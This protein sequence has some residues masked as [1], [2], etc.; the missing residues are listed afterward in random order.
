MT[1]SV[2][3]A[4]GLLGCS[5]AL[6][7]PAVASSEWGP[8][9]WLDD[10]GEKLKSTPEFY[11]DI[12]V[13]RLA[14]QYAAKD[15]P[16]VRKAQPGTAKAD[17]EDFEDALKSGRL[18]PADGTAV[19]TAHKDMRDWLEATDRSE[20][21]KTAEVDS[22]FAAYHQAAAQFRTGQLQD[23][24]AAWEKLLQR[25][26]GDRHYRS[27]WAAYMIGKCCLQQPDQRG[28][29]IEWFEKCR[30]LAC[31]GFVDSPGLAA[32]SFGWQARAEYDSGDFSAS[33][34]HYLQQL[35][36]GDTSAIASLKLMVPDRD[37]DGINLPLS[38]RTLPPQSQEDA[39]LDHRTKAELDEAH[40]RASGRLAAAV[41]DP[42]LRQLVTAHV[43]ATAAPLFAPV[44]ASRPNAWLDAVNKAGL[45]KIEGAASL[46]WVAYTAGRFPEAE[47]WLKLDQPA[48][49]LGQWLRA[50]LALR[51]GAFAEASG[52]L[53]TVLPELPEAANRGDDDEFGGFFPKET[54]A[55]DLGAA[56]LA[57]GKLIEA[58]TIF[59]NGGCP[60]DA[61]YLA[62][63]V[64][65]TAELM[66]FVKAQAFLD[67]KELP[68]LPTGTAVPDE[69]ERQESLMKLT[70]RRLIREGRTA[71]GRLLLDDEM[72]GIFD[73]FQVVTEL[74]NDPKQPAAS[75][76]RALFDAARLVE[77]H[78]Y[79][80]MGSW[81]DHGDDRGDFGPGY[82][83][84]DEIILDRL[85]GRTRGGGENDPGT[86][87]GRLYIPASDAERERLKKFS[88]ERIS[89]GKY[90]RL[91]SALAVKAAALLPDNAEETADVLNQA[92]RWIQDL[93]NHGADRIYY[94]LEKRCPHAVIGAAVIKK[95]WFIDPD[96]PWTR[97]PVFPVQ[98]QSGNS[99]E[100]AL[101]EK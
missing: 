37:L 96:G 46:G 52:I 48:T 80:W 86:K 11:W 81:N 1:S 47:K 85:A 95:H 5:L 3:I 45:T 8:I 90:R 34:R 30:Q 70:G 2:R 89:I 66:S 98:E 87:P 77:A 58:F 6:I 27:V 19:K 57:Q 61:A 23:A 69:R 18:K 31:D 60:K 44:N 63:H 10:G 67:W 76:G 56:L 9:R 29:A 54:A 20:P 94:Q 32:D 97:E 64:L 79:S 35:A 16:F 100:P 59:W 25:P 41:K 72:R 92:G 22:E 51:K 33:A 74:G 75:R 62:E 83:G 53:A 7:R 21:P 42:I 17:L 12:E 78:G 43:L 14:R 91:A 73:R 38:F 88:S 82:D 84:R 55:A 13:T 40:I 26:E 65:T 24:K 99:N 93:D 4:F 36:L 68:K 101:P 39:Y 49:P 50:K 15:L 71:E 28:E